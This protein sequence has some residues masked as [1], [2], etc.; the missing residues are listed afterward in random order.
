ML[1]FTHL[2]FVFTANIVAS[3]AFLIPMELVVET[4]HSPDLSNQQ[5]VLFSVLNQQNHPFHKVRDESLLNMRFGNPIL[6]IVF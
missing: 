5:K 4:N 2:S 3:H 6:G 1:I